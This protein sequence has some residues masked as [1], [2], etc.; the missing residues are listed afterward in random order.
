M[1]T[2]EGIGHKQRSLQYSTETLECQSVSTIK[3]KLRVQVPGH[4]IHVASDAIP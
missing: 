3:I 1:L 4:Q 2:I